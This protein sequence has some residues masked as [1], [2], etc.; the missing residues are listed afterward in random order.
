MGNVT[1]RLLLTWAIVIA[2]LLFVLRWAWILIV[3]ALGLFVALLFFDGWF[4]GTAWLQVFV[5][6]THQTDRF[7]DWVANWINNGGIT[8]IGN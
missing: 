5:A 3:A 7:A 4:G 8:A 2:I 1:P 6:I